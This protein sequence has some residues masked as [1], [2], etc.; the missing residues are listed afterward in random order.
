MDPTT[1]DTLY[2]T[3]T[4]DLSDAPW[5]TLLETVAITGVADNLQLRQA[6]GLDRDRLNRLIEK[7]DRLAERL[8]PILAELDHT[9][10]RFGVR[11][12][13]PNIYLLGETGAA[14]LRRS[15]STWARDARACGLKEDTPIAHALAMLEVH[16][17]ATQAGL[18]VVTDRELDFGEGKAIRPDHLVTLADGQRAIIEIEQAAS[19]DLLR[20][21]REGIKHRAR[22]F[23]SAES[24]G[25]S[26]IV[27]MLINLPRGKILDRTLHLWE[28]AIRSVFAPY[29]H[30]PYRIIA[31]PLAEFLEAPDWSL[32]PD[33]ANRRWIDLTPAPSGSD[34]ARSSAARHEGAS[35]HN[36][37]H[38]A[39]DT[40][41]PKE[42]LRTSPHDDR[43]LLEALWQV[44]QESAS[45]RRWRADIPD[46]DPEFFDLMRLIYSASHD[47]TL[48]PLDRAAFPRASVFL[49]MHYLQLHPKLKEQLVEA[50]RRGENASRW[51]VTLIRQWMQA[52]I[53]AFLEYHGFASGDTLRAEAVVSDWHD[54]DAQHAI[55]VVVSI[56]SGEVLMAREA[57]GVV[58]DRR[59]LTSAERA[60]AWV[61]HAL[62]AHARHLDLGRPPAFW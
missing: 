31:L 18:T 7:L 61:L 47:P 9:L 53:N 57:N 56:T 58:P 20:R 59:E 1:L 10:P 5:L 28:Q 38:A 45:K 23:A 42:W 51:N 40:Q 15:D 55:D 62:F 49:L 2:Q 13:A 36:S 3:I 24:R 8:P 12:R 34:Q 44:F 25:V 41:A 43:L 60:L 14:L 19:A 11:G 6:T 32:Q 33:E 16:Q 29:A 46:P 4:H 27:R 39:P 54:V 21:I 35:T 52:V 17:A 26:P 48:S 30:P 22:F 37:H 50:L